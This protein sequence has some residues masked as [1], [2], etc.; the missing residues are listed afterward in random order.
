MPCHCSRLLSILT[1]LIGDYLNF[2]TFDDGLT[3]KGR[4]LPCGEPA[5]VFKRIFTDKQLF[6]AIQLDRDDVVDI[7]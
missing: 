5:Q 4:L 2:W 1:P 3:V 7:R 6:G